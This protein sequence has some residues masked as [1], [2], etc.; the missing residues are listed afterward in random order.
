M[1]SV[2]K[3]TA[4][5]TISSN[6]K[7]LG[8]SQSGPVAIINCLH[9]DNRSQSVAETLFTYLLQEIVS[10]ERIFL[11][12]DS[13][14]SIRLDENF[15]NVYRFLVAKNIQPSEG[16]PVLVAQYCREYKWDQYLSG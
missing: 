8:R 12:I 10:V 2:K 5:S 9:V 16:R 13:G 15:N 7:N 14:N 11:S 1:L 3:R 4:A 6:S